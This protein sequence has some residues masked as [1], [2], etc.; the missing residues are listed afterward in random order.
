MKTLNEWSRAELA[1][2]PNR[3]WGEPSTYDSVLI[4]STR[5][6]HSSG[7]ACMYVIGVRGGQPVEIAADGCDD[8]EWK[9]PEMESIANG[10]VTIGQMRMDCAFRSGAVHFWRDKRRFKVGLAL[11]SVCIEVVRL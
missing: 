1:A 7:W 6:K 8:I 4:L 10:Q 2:L 3:E 5:R 9:L 11:S